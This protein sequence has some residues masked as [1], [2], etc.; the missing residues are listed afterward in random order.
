MKIHP[1]G[2]DLFHADGRRNGQIDRQTYSH[3]EVNSRHPQFC[4]NT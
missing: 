3:H 1:V 4:K 2:Q